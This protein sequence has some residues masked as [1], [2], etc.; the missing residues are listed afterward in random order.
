MHDTDTD[1]AARAAAR[2][3]SRSIQLQ[4]PAGSGKTTVLAQRFL[5]ALAAVDEPEEVLAITFTRKAA[6]EMRERVLAALEDRLPAT[7][8]EAALWRELRAAVHAQATRRE[9]SL[10]EL[11][12]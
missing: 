8:S 7:Q 4:A 10:A 5:A 3:V 11:P 12:Q 1:A 2:D 6:G 9:W